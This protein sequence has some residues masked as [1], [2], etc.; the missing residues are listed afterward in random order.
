MTLK[1]ALNFTAD[2]VNQN[3]KEREKKKAWTGWHTIALIY[4]SLTAFK[5]EIVHRMMSCDGGQ[6]RLSVL[7]KAHRDDLDE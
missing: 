7:I 3:K 1:A 2:Q 4:E 5:C 6:R